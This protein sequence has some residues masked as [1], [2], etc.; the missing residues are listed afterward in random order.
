MSNKFK[1]QRGERRN[2]KMNKPI[3]TSFERH[4]D[5]C[6]QILKKYLNYIRVIKGRSNNT[7]KNYYYSLR[8]FFAYMFWRKGLSDIILN[9]NE[10]DLS[11]ID[12]NFLNSI[13]YNEI[14]EYLAYCTDELKYSATSR[15]FFFFFF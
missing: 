10:V 13:T 14:L 6:P 2:K 15:S 7:V 12:C 4:L 9:E 11:L 5:E 3:K 1:R 8:T